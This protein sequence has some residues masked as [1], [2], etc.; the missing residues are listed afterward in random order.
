LTNYYLSAIVFIISG[1][2]IW[3][4]IESKFVVDW[5]D[6]I[7]WF[8]IGTLIIYYE[9]FFF[10]SFYSRFAY[11]FANKK[12]E[13]LSKNT[14]VTL[15][16]K[17]TELMETKSAYS[18]PDLTLSDIARDIGTNKHYVSKLINEG[19]KKNFT[20]Y[21][22]EYRIKAFIEAVE[23]DK[24]NNTFLFYAFEVGFN[25]KSSFNRAFKKMTNKTPSEYFSNI[26]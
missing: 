20:D 2:C 26:K 12:D 22:N 3:Q 18:N 21:I 9:Y 23:T 10:T 25:S 14:W 4:K 7:L 16:T 24:N 19:F 5:L 8:G 1:I 11:N 15:K 6:N 13:I 17:L